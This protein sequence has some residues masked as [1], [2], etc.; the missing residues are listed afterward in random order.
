MTASTSTLGLETPD[1]PDARP[2]VSDALVRR[3][4]MVFAAVI[5]P[6][7]LALHQVV[8]PF[9]WLAALLLFVTAVSTRVFGV[10]LPGK[11]F[12]SF[13]AGI[14]IASVL[15]LGWAAGAVS[16]GAGVL[17]GDLVA[18]RLPL[19]V[20]CG[21]ASHLATACIVSGSLYALM[22]G[23]AGTPAFAAS[24]WW[25]LTL[26]IALFFITVN[27]TFYLQLAL[28][29]ALAWVDA[30]LTAR[31]E[32]TMAVMAT[33]LSLVALRL[34]YPL[35]GVRWALAE[36]T[37]V[38]LAVL[39]HWLVR[40]GVAGDSLLL[41]QRLTS[42]ISARADL[43]RT[44]EEIRPLTRTLVPWEAMEIAAYDAEHG[45]MIPV[46]GTARELRHTARLVADDQLA[47]RA[48]AC[49]RAVTDPP[50]TRARAMAPQMRGSRIV[51]PLQRGE[52]V[53]G[54]WTVSHGQ[55]EMYRAHDAGLL[56][57]V[58]PHLALSLS[59]DALIQPVLDASEQTTQHVE[60]ITGTTQQLHASSQESASSA[61]RMAET[62]RGVTATLA[63]SAD[64]A[65]AAR[66]TAER[67][68]AEGRLMQESGESMVRNARMVRGATGE[69]ITQLSAAS[70]VAQDGVAEVSRLHEISDAVQ[71]FGQTITAL[72]DQTSLLALNAAVEAAR[73]GAHGR[74]FAVV[75]QEVR[76]LADRSAAEADGMERAVRDIRAALD[77]TVTFMQRTGT[78]VR[79]VAQ[80]STSWLGELDRMVVAAE[81]V[82]GAG[83]RI[84]DAAQQ[85]AERSAAMAQ[86]LGAAQEDAGRA[87]VETGT[88][89]SASTQQESAIESLNEAALQL[90]GLGRRL[91][92]AVA[93]VRA[94]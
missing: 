8:H 22:G 90:N 67:T 80:A 62:V 37:L 93:A 26:C 75:A 59:L 45:V 79:T 42:M 50:G 94:E 69:A 71:R 51:A 31:W 88:V 72:A 57:Y 43:A 81:E 85:S 40:R 34:A 36:G 30:R 54:F 48:L 46:A 3:S 13:T 55:T 60:S 20:A 25:R 52:R 56:E 28:S 14:G 66:G 63:A 16:C 4:V 86:A 41:I 2:W 77:R 44:L 92:G 23:P 61:R 19:R 82:A 87:S 18:R 89:A 70:R 78:E 39:T 5:V 32:G 84:M 33:L 24:N 49:G 21:N 38:G 76:S 53:V 47:S 1:T 91:A 35:D 9:P 11:G 29:P 65:R 6:V 12:T 15:A 64:E 10:P 27:S 7:G 58:A 68:V 74:G 83:A 73:A 17:V